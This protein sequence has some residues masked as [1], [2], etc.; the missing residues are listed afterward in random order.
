LE[1]ISTCLGRSGEKKKTLQL[2][3]KF[4]D[5]LRDVKFSVPSKNG[6][7]KLSLE[8]EKKKLTIWDLINGFFFSMHYLKS[9]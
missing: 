2:H 1:E 7:N 5:V 9:S 6:Q 3:G 8:Q 4:K